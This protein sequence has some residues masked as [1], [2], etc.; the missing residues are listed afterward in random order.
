VVSV[1][2]ITL[3]RYL[4]CWSVTKEEKVVKMDIKRILEL[5]KMDGFYVNNSTDTIKDQVQKLVKEYEKQEEFIT[6]LMNEA[7]A[8]N[9]IE[10]I[11]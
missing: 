1:Q 4:Y 3:L 8:K 9:T 10:R 11:L 7:T 2:F 6:L 5:M